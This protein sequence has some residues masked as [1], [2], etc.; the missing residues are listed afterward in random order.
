VITKAV[1]VYAYPSEQPGKEPPLQ[2]DQQPYFNPI[3]FDQHFLAKPAD[4]KQV[5]DF[6]TVEQIQPQGLTAI[7]KARLAYSCLP[8]C[9]QW[10]CSHAC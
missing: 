8:Q 7:R 4:V 10:A 1:D 9:A 2:N 5:W 6:V 3:G